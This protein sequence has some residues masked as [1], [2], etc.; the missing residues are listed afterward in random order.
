MLDKLNRSAVIGM[1]LLGAV[2]VG[3]A[4]PAAAQAQSRMR[5]L[6]P[7]FINAEGKT[8]R[9]GDRLADRIRDRMKEMPKHAPAEEKDV[10]DALKKYGL[11]ESEM[12]CIQ[13]RQLASTANVAQ[14][15]LCGTL[16]ESTGQVTAAFHPIEGGVDPFEVPPFQFQSPEQGAQQVVQ[17]FETY[18]RQ[19]DLVTF[20]NDRIGSQS[21]QE[22]LDLCTQATELNPRSI[23]AHYARGSALLQLDRNEEALEA[24]RKVLEIDP[25][26]SDALKAAG[27][28]ASKLGRRDVSQQYFDQYLELNPGDEN[29][30]LTLAHQLANEGDPAG[31]L[32][33]VEQA[34]VAPDATA[35]LLEYAGHFAMNAGITRQQEAGPAAGGSAAEANTYFEKAIQFYERAVQ[36]KGDSADAT[37]LRNL[38]VAYKNIGNRDKA[39]ETGARATAGSQDAQTWLF[40]SDVLREAERT[41]EAVQ[42]MDR[43]AQ[44]DPNLPGIATRKAVMLLETDDLDGAV[45]A[46]KQGLAN[47]SL[48][49]DQAETL[50]QQMAVK[51]F[52]T[53]QAGRPAQS[54]RYFEAARQIGKSERTVGMINFFHGYALL[55]QA[56]AILRE[57]TTAAP[58]RRAKPM[59]DQA[60]AYLESAAAYTEQAQLRVQLLSDVQQYLDVADALIRSGR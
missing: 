48:A 35:S 37:V 15:V 7:P 56:D 1:A 50:A 26:H 53:T 5:V 13:W 31:A 49:A 40:Y 51:G 18:V 16:N 32:S 43:A 19:L 28:V 45:A 52:N 24:Y 55:K 33:L 44:L 60:K 57:A 22:A 20:C 38:M 10:K 9:N 8:T 29:V 36:M 2:L 17:A 14:L 59:L 46:V 34:A 25:I 41:Q 11:K 6:V 30:R 54:I 42:A 47:N 27:I 39:L 58:A 3:D 21:W 4:A 12:S 23:S